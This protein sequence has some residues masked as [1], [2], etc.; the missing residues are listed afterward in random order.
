M[1][2]AAL[3]RQALRFF[4]PQVVLVAR[5]CPIDGDPILQQQYLNPCAGQYILLQ[6]GEVRW[7]GESGV[8]SQSRR[9]LAG[10]NKLSAMWLKLV[11]PEEAEGERYEVYERVLASIC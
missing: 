5:H 4:I 2:D 10:A 8:F 9:E 6:D 3:C 11:D 7:H 1:G